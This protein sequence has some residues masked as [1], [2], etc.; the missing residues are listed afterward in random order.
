MSHKLFVQ[1][2]TECK[3]FQ[4]YDFVLAIFVINIK[5]NK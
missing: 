1:V 5:I 4:F 3:K 2:S